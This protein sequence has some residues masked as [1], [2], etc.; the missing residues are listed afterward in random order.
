MPCRGRQDR[1][2]VSV[3]EQ[4]LLTFAADT[5]RSAWP[6]EL[7]LL[8]HQE[9]R[10][11]WQMD[12]LVR[13]LRASPSVVAEALAELR[14]FG[15]IASDPQGAYQFAA[16]SLASEQLVAELVELYSRKPRA[17]MRAI[18]SAPNDRIRTFADAFRLRKD[19]S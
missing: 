10:Q 7:L 11:A 1:L 3:T 2:G 13:E 5:F 6:L 12:D 9:P 19:P 4:E 17:I 8:I 16:S 15:V 18:L 14:R